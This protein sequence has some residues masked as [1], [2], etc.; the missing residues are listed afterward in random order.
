MSSLLFGLVLDKFG[1]KITNAV[2]VSFV[3]GGL[4]FLSLSGNEF[5]WGFLVGFSLVSAGGIASFQSL[6][7]LT[8]LF[9]KSKGMKK[10]FVF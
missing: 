6:A 1:P 2:G 5:F 8:N 9:P 4:L 7:H 10:P 3:S